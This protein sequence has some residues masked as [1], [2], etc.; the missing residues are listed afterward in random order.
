MYNIILGPKMLVISNIDADT[1][2]LL[3]TIINK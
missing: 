2:L 3:K 1:N